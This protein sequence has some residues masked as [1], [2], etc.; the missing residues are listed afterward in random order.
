[1]LIEF[2]PIMK[3]MHSKT[4]WMR[5]ITKKLSCQRKLPY[6]ILLKIAWEVEFLFRQSSRWYLVRTSM[7]KMLITNPHTSMGWIGVLTMRSGE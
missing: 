6:S 1:M 7:K 4:T 3:I 5:C 2:M